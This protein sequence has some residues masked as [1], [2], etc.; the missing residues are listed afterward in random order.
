M[1][2]DVTVLD[3][4]LYI[5]VGPQI[6]PASH[7]IKV[8][9]S[10]TVRTKATGSMSQTRTSSAYK[11]TQVSMPPRCINFNS[12]LKP[13]AWM[14]YREE[15]EFISGYNTCF[16]FVVQNSIL[17]QFMNMSQRPNFQGVLNR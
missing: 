6:Q 8:I 5:I 7:I 11:V 2:L 14:M 3:L 1:A 4:C 16:W 10:N 9:Y 17:T 13:R 15:I 12:G